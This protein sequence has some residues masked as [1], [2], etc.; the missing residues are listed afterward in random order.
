MGQPSE[1]LTTEEGVGRTVEAS[2]I[3][4]GGTEMTRGDIFSMPRS[5]A[6]QPPIV[7]KFAVKTKIPNMFEQNVS[8]YR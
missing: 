7:L 4:G 6:T 3:P 1:Q 8:S 2:G 5:A